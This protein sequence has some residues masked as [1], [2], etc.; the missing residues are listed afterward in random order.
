M[1]RS[2]DGAPLPP[3]DPT[4]LERL[5]TL[6]QTELAH[7]PQHRVSLLVEP[8]GDDACQV[9]QPPESS[10]HD[11]ETQPGPASAPT[12]AQPLVAIDPD[13]AR[14]PASNAKLFTSAAALLLLRDR[15]RFV[16][17]F[18]QPRA[19]GPVYVWGTGDPL[20]TGRQLVQI[21]AST[22]GARREAR[23]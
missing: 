17:E 7:L 5:R 6:V 11:G 1:N 23:R 15:Y 21:A 19:G 2:Q 13:A 12:C 3:D 14:V 22:Q 9:P 16:T 4:R 10:D 20:L 8:V 18:S